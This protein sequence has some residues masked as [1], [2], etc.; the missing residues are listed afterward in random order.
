M[1]LNNLVVRHKAFGLGTVVETDGK[2]M[3]VRF[4]VG[5]KHFVYPDSF[6]KF[7]TL[8]DGTV[9]EEIAADLALSIA[10][11]QEIADK[12]NEEILQSMSGKVY[13][14]KET[15]EN[16]EEHDGDGEEKPA[17]QD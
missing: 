1:V 6:E 2:Y 11:K 14:G 9:N 3:T 16:E 17:S 13:P 15:M 12:K 4:E 7:L 10:H 5:D 8:E